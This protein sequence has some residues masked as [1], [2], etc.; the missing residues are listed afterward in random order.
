MG[1]ELY[2]EDSSF[3]SALRAGDRKLLCVYRSAIID[4]QQ[5]RASMRVLLTS[6]RSLTK[7]LDNIKFNI[8]AIGVN[9]LAIIMNIIAKIYGLIPLFIIVIALQIVLIAQIMREPEVRE[10]LYGEPGMIGELVR[11]AAMLEKA[12]ENPDEDDDMLS[13]M[14][15]TD[16]MLLSKK[17]ALDR[18]LG[19]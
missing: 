18:E 3:V 7:K 6:K 12:A 11:S 4:E 8:L 19:L 14:L 10:V 9:L 17:Q 2:H 16:D 1:T 15:D 13:L 5:R